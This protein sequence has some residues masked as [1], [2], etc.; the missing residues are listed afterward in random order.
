VA[1]LE[2]A[3]VRLQKD[4]YAELVDVVSAKIDTEL[5]MYLPKVQTLVFDF[6]D[7]RSEVKKQVS[8][9]TK[10]VNE[11]GGKGGNG[12]NAQALK[13]QQKSQNS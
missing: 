11:M 1:K 12:A 6:E 13:D 7:F 8:A 3:L 10:Q 2:K 4:G 5:G 9:L